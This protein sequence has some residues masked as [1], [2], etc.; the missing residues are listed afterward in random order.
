[1]SECDEKKRSKGVCLW[2]C[3][4][5]QIEL[6]EEGWKKGEGQGLIGWKSADQ[7][8]CKETTK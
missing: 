4:N 5:W 1:M 7:A 3:M 6:S 8:Q 2:V